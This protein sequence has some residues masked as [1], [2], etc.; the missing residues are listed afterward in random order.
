M[1][2]P[3]PPPPLILQEATELIELQSAGPRRFMSVRPAWIP[4]SDLPPPPPD[5]PLVPNLA[6]IVHKA[7]YGACVFIQSALAAYKSLGDN[8]RGI[9][10]HVR[11]TEYPAL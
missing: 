5:L 2:S 7:T 11:D 8:A 6:P 1:S 4:G 9:G 3:T 10:V